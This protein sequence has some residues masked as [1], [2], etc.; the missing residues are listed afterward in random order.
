MVQPIGNLTLSFPSTVLLV[1]P[2][3]VLPTSQ[4]RLGLDLE[5][6]GD[7]ALGYRTARHAHFF[8]VHTNPHA[9]PHPHT[10]SHRHAHTHPSH[11]P[12]HIYTHTTYTVSTFSKSA[13]TIIFYYVAG[14]LDYIA[15]LSF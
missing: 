5:G 13:F 11:T 10:H 6:S 15:I 14:N 2:T 12:T 7:L 8:L 3:V 4:F 9:N 1:I